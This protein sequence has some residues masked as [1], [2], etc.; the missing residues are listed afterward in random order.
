MRTDSGG[1]AGGDHSGPVEP[2][3]RAV[4]L[5][6]ILKLLEADYCRAVFISSDVGQGATRLLRELAKEWPSQSPVVAIHGTPSLANI[7]YGVL[8]PHLRR[9]ATAFFASPIEVL[10]EFLAVIEEQP[11]E[12]PRS[13]AVGTTASSPLLIVDD[14]DYIDGATAALAVNLAQAGR[15]KLVL[16]HRP[17]NEIADPL[18][19]L[20][21]AG[22]AER[23]QLLP[24]TQDRAHQYCMDRLGGRIS[25][26]N[27]WYLWSMA[28]G[29]PLLLSLLLTDMLESG[30]LGQ[31]SG[32]WSAQH[33]AAPPSPALQGVVRE[34]LRG[35]S[36]EGRHALNLVALSEPVGAGTLAE[37]VGRGA[38]KELRD[39]HLIQDS[40]GQH[41]QLQLINRVYGEVIRETVPRATSMLLHRELVDRLDAEDFNPE[42]MLRRV[43]WALDSGDSVPGDRLLQASIYAGK[44]FQ[45]PLALKLADAITDSEYTHLSRG[46]KARAHYN[47]GD[48]ATAGALL[49]GVEQQAEDLRELLF[50]AMLHSATRTALG[51]PPELLSQDAEAVRLSGE[52]IAGKDPA[53]ATQ[54]MTQVQERA[55]ILDMMVFSRTGNYRQLEAKVEAVLAAPARENDADYWLNRAAALALDAE[56]ICAL[57]SPLQGRARAAEALAIP[58]QEDHDVFFLPEMIFARAQTASLAA[59]DWDD[60]E[61]VLKVVSVDQGPAIVAFGGGANAARGMV[62][63]RQGKFASALKVL[64]SGVEALRLNDPQHL[65]G[66]CTGMALYAASLLGEKEA[67]NRLRVEYRERGGMFVVTAHERAFVAAGLGHL[68]RDGGGLG[69]LMTLADK[70]AAEEQRLVELNALALAMD[71]GVETVAPRLRRVAEGVEGSWA[72]AMAAFGWGVEEGTAQSALTAGEALVEAGLFHH[73][74]CA[75]NVAEE[76]AQHAGQGLIARRAHVAWRHASDAS[77]AGGGQR[78]GI[79]EMDTPRGRLTRREL[80]IVRMAANGT[81]NKDIAAALHVSVRTVEGHIYRSYGKLGI[82]TRSELTLFPFD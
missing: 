81:S 72:E 79:T 36:V 15:V 78:E 61:Q 7:P 55:D 34:H 77:G 21:A 40:P 26:G 53:T 23:F 32:L 12:F 73:A 42:S 49:D 57:G 24:L 62:Y 25:S 28:G 31:A 44:L 27:S 10:R 80:E 9:S 47:L 17:Q 50:S 82:T 1:R 30:G 56:R 41:E 16:S 43:V 51:Q 33:S 13:P 63:L 71:F 38:V 59:G 22:F 20:W 3:C 68:G 69:A 35:L 29:N 52:R 66:F 67:A 60:V 11:A 45:S 64:V 70:A 2:F 19:K 37:I 74:A 75:F 5:W 76:R 65:L 18:P 14:A 4:E 8:T 6:D 46:L 54:V 48:Y 39:R 58:Q